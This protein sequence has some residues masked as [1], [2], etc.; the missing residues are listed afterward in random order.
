MNIAINLAINEDIEFIS[1]K[2]SE[3]VLEKNDFYLTHS[4]SNLKKTEFK[5]NFSFKAFKASSPKQLIN[6]ILL[7]KHIS[8]LRKADKTYL[9]SA[10]VANIFII[11]FLSLFKTN[12]IVV[13]HDALTH[14]KGVRGKIFKLQNDIIYFFSDNVIVFSDYC[15]RIS[16]ELYGIP[17]PISLPLPT[18]SEQY[19]REN[20]TVKKYDFVWWGRPE[21]YKGI[22]LLYEFSK[23]INEDNLGLLIIAKIN[24]LDKKYLDLYDAN[25]VEIISEYL[26][27]D[28][29]ISIIQ[30]VWVNICP[31]QSATQS[32]IISFCTYLGIPTIAHDVGGL[33][34][35]I[36]DNKNGFLVDN[37]LNVNALELLN[38]CKKIKQDDIQKLYEILFSSA[39]MQR[40]L[41]EQIKY[42]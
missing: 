7:I 4:N 34:S 28:K 10:N 15:K 26:E 14:Y 29:L 11:P 17:E 23:K 40:L 20:N 8:I 24:P 9:L 42:N 12:L 30:S 33:S 1:N 32:G 2:I 5:I 21:D 35:Q 6:F 25:N 31:Y 39:A 38:K 27:I 36:F 18:P 3:V 22:N 13:V 37:I 19:P 41:K 16:Q